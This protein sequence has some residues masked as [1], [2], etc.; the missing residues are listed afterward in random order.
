MAA[1]I[2]W[3]NIDDSSDEIDDNDGVITGGRGFFFD[4]RVDE[5]TGDGNHVEGL[6]TST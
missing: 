5:S 2:L 1:V 6:R 4:D 3:N